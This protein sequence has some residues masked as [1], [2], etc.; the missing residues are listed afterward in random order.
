MRHKISGK[1]L[2]RTSSHRT[3]L[4][5]NLVSSL[6]LHDQIQTTVTKAKFLRPSVEKLITKAKEGTL[7]ARRL[8]ISRIKNKEAVTRLMDVVAK[9]YLNRPGGYT[10][11]IKSG[12][13]LGDAAPMAYIELL[14]WEQSIDK[15]ALKI[16]MAQ[17]KIATENNQ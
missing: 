13:R 5:C 1:K 9:R 16:Q 7:A 4:L 8:L 12:F 6:I 2:N 10:R 14:N 15:S 11:I 17:N 3:A